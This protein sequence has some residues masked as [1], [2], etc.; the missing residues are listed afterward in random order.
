MTSARA[1]PP[2]PPSFTHTGP[3]TP[4]A[5]HYC[6]LASEPCAF[7]TF[8]HQSNFRTAPESV[9]RNF[10]DRFRRS[11]FQWK[12]WTR[13]VRKAQGS[14]TSMIQRYETWRALLVLGQHGHM[15]HRS[16]VRTPHLFDPKI[17]LE[18]PS[19]MGAVS[20]MEPEL[21]SSTKLGTVRVKAR[22]TARV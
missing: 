22:T 10:R 4:L 15:F 17:L 18:V 6:T 20:F 9:T 5:V 1:T 13:S 8:Q 16:H 7:R 12:F 3:C 19:G 2:S 14:D 11:D 21:D